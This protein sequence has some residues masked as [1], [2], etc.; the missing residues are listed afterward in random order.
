VRIGFNGRYLQKT[1]S[2]IEYYLLNLIK[3]LPEIDPNNE[4]CIFFNNNPFVN[5]GI[6]SL[7][8]KSNIMIYT[9]N[10]P[11]KSRPSRLLWDYLTIKSD[12]QKVNIDI[13]HGPSFSVPLIKTCPSVVT[14]HD[15]AWIYR[16]KS[17]TRSNRYYFKLLLPL[18]V[19]RA[20]HIVTNSFSSKKDITNLLKV[21]ENKIS[22]V[23]PGVSPVFK[24]IGDTEKLNY[25]RQ[26]YG[27]T[28]NFI[29]NVSGLITPRKNLINLIEAYAKLLRSHK[30]EDQLVIVGTPAWSY[31]KIFET[32]KRLNLTNDLIFT[33]TVPIDELV[34]LYNAAEL[35]VF[36]SKY[37]GFGFPI[38]ESMAC[39]TPSVASNISSIPEL[40]GDAGLLFRPDNQENLAEAIDKVLNDKNLSQKYVTKGLSRVSKFN[41]EITARQTL[42][43]YEQ[44]IC[45][46]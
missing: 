1:M 46:L 32:A 37:E 6:K 43:V 39:G 19:K 2:G 20:N 8:E 21:P 27:I 17:Y 10:L 31:T 13:F 28:R 11:S 25:V 34:C 26:K 36:P 16:P 5:E 3:N 14:I 29:I 35:N 22:V 12:L 44:V 23:Y 9:S 30:I 45:E 41:W 4:Y 38:V 18:V 15:L 7:L 42:N 33:G 24:K 40:L